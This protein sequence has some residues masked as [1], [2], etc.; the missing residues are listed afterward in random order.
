MD[1]VHKDK[2]GPTKLAGSVAYKTDV[3]ENGCVESTLTE[4]ELWIWPG[5]A[6]TEAAVDTLVASTE[7]LMKHVANR[8]YEL[9]LAPGDYLVCAMNA[10]ANVAL[11]AGH[12]TTLNVL[13]IYGPTQFFAAAPGEKK[14][15]RLTSIDSK[16]FF[17]SE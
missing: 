5:P 9:L 1:D 7:P 11:T 3:G 8:S 12:T 6:D 2:P 15:T 16:R 4:A 13:T 17:V 10:C 14:T